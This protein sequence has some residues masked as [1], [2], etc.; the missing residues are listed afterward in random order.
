[1]KR[2]AVGVGL[3]C[4]VLSGSCENPRHEYFSVW[5]DGRLCAAPLCGGFFFKKLNASS[6]RCFDGSERPECYAFDLD[7]STTNLSYLE[8]TTVRNAAWQ[9]HALVLRGQFVQGRGETPDV[10]N[11]TVSEAWQAQSGQTPT[12]EFYVARDTGLEC[13]TYPCDH[14]SAKRVNHPAAGERLFAGLEV[15]P[16]GGLPP[17]ASA[18]LAARLREGGVMVS[19]H[20]EPISGP[21][22]TSSTLL[23]SEYYFRLVH[24]P[25]L[26]CPFPGVVPCTQEEADAWRQ[27]VAEFEAFRRAASVCTTDT[28]CTTV[29][30]HS[31]FNAC[32]GV[33]VNERSVT[34]VVERARELAARIGAT[35]TLNDCPPPARGPACIESLCQRVTD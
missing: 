10:P 14:I 33:A 30:V 18:K 8:T 11:F 31:P 2:W 35:D 27:A 23:A 16:F 25:A 3:V 21:S 9:R 5:R 6:T 4:G 1:M 29:D 17:D 7:F 28:E 22:G 15:P 34:Q 13:V 24:N 32:G 19:G 12:D 26:D 20:A